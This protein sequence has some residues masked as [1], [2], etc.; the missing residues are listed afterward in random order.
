MT[1][2]RLGYRTPKRTVSAAL[3]MRG[4][5]KRADADS[6]TVLRLT[7]FMV[8]ARSRS[9][10]S[11]A[12]HDVG[13]FAAQLGGLRRVSVAR[14]WHIDGHVLADASRRGRHDGD[15]VGEIDGLVDVV[16]DVDDR[17]RLRQPGVDQ[18]FLQRHAFDG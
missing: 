16:R 6:R 17:A 13:Q 11:E 7:F 15:A 10:A 8:L 5:A 2:V 4:A 3:A 18:A 9:V 12:S 14:A 1:V